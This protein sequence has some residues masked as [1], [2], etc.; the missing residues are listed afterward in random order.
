MKVK[1]SR[2]LSLRLILAMLCTTLFFSSVF[3][4]SAEVYYGDVNK[5]GAINANDALLALQ[6]SVS[7]TTL[8]NDRFQRA[9]VSGDK[10]VNANDALLILQYSVKIIEVFPVEKSS[11]VSLPWSSDTMVYAQTR[12][13]GSRRHPHYLPAIGQLYR[14]RRRSVGLHDGLYRHYRRSGDAV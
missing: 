2:G 8:D 7:L 5:D 3:T 9:D 6:H 4:A 10:A 1:H 12:R 14:Y 13:N 11:L